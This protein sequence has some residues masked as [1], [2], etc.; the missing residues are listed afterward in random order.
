MTKREKHGKMSKYGIFKK[1]YKSSE[2]YQK[3]YQKAYRET[4]G[5]QLNDKQKE[6]RKNN[7]EKLK[8]Y[9]KKYRE[10]HREEILLYNKEFYKANK[11][12]VQA[13]NRAYR[14][15]NREKV[16]AKNREWQKNNP[17][18][19]K[20]YRENNRGIF[21]AIQAKR[22]S[23]ILQATPSWVNLEAI[24]EIYVRCPKGY[25]VDHIVPLKGKNV[26]GF[27]VENNLQYL[28]AKENMR[29]G[30]R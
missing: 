11:E 4:N 2:E 19:H 30:N 5:Q 29:K 18:N 25:H 24:K 17:E 20:R 28:K 22:R 23:R 6:N 7:P 10:K 27:H 13:K 8:G 16:Y 12:K 26:C 9:N 15:A 1:D 21:T 3:A 14:E